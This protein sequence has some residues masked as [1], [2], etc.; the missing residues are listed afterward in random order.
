MQTGRRI[1]KAF[2]FLCAA[3]CLC[4][5][6]GCKQEKTAPAPATNNASGNPLSA[7][8]DYIGAV[9]QA[10]KS[11]E[12]SLSASGLDHAIKLFAAEEGRYPKTLDELVS[13]G[14]ISS[15]PNPPVGMKYDYDAKTGIIK[16]VPQ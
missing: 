9:G 1:M 16:V 14:T 2:T 3:A 15:L 13:K 4:L 7:P 11:M 5:S 12:K 10:K 8:V 6:A